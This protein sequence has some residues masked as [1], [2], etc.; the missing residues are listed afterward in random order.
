MLDPYFLVRQALL[1]FLRG[2]DPHVPQDALCF[3]ARNCEISTSLPYRLGIPCE[4]CV[5]LLRTQPGPQ[6]W[7]VPLIRDIFA[8]GNHICFSLSDDFYSEAVRRI[9]GD[10]PLPALP[11]EWSEA[12]AYALCRMR[13]LARK[14]GN[15]CPAS[16]AVHRALWQTFSLAGECPNRKSKRQRAAR[17]LLEM[18]DSMGAEERINM[19]AQMGTVGTCAAILLNYH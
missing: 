2:I 19:A 17:A 10:A 8:S 12:W 3:S 15:A 4:E 13:M 6:V 18:L 16:S 5:S 14:G 11:E 1:D 7:D 9:T